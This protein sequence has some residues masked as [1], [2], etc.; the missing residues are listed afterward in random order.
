MSNHRPVVKNRRTDSSVRPST[1]GVWASHPLKYKNFRHHAA[2]EGL[3]GFLFSAEL[4]NTN[5]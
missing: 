4:E 1:I 2:L 3:H 5:D